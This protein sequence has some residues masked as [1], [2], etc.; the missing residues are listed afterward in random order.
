MVI[1]G[2]FCTRY[3]RAGGNKL[4][5]KLLENI[6]VSVHDTRGR[7]ESGSSVSAHQLG[8][9]WH[10]ARRWGERELPDTVKKQ[11]EFLEA[12]KKEGKAAFPAAIKR[13]SRPPASPGRR[14]HN[15]KLA[16]SY[17]TSIT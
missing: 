8:Y 11:M 13:R 5:H 17:K 1:G 10:N 16:P 4:A 6:G 15:T 3:A 14:P 2:S 7:G 9:Y 12:L